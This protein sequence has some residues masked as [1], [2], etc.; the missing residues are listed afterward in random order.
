MQQDH[1]NFL[2]SNEPEYSVVVTPNQMEVSKCVCILFN[3]RQTVYSLLTSLKDGAVVYSCYWRTSVPRS[4]RLPVS[5]HTIQKY[6]SDPKDY[7]LSVVFFFFLLTTKLS[8]CLPLDTSLSLDT[9]A[10]L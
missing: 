2:P 8:I 10:G 4:E 3:F 6:I 1:V 7:L 5:L 9:E